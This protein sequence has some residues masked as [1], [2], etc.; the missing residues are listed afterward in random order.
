MTVLLSVANKVIMLSDVMMSVF[1]LSVVMLSVIML[2]DVMLS[3]VTPCFQ[4]STY[5][6]SAKIKEIYNLKV[7]RIQFYILI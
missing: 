5:G 4:L 1:M 2:N 3:V 6:G 7:V